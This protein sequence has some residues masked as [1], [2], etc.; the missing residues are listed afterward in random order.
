[1]DVYARAV[2][3]TAERITMSAVPRCA[4]SWFPQASP[5][6]EL[7]I[8]VKAGIQVAG[9]KLAEGHFEGFVLSTLAQLQPQ[10]LDRR[11]PISSH[12]KVVEDGVHIVT[13]LC[14]HYGEFSTLRQSPRQGTVSFVEGTPKEDLIWCGAE[15]NLDRW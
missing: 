1:M 10:I 14:D 11:S 9:C 13:T 4:Q 2:A 12:A 7:T 3:G 6:V 15:D 8:H 5:E